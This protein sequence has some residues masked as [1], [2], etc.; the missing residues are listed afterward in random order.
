MEKVKNMGKEFSIRKIS[1]FTKDILMMVKEMDLGYSKF[2]IVQEELP[3][4]LGN[5]QMETN[6]DKVNTLTKMDLSMKDSG[7]IINVMAL[8]NWC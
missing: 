5:L 4:I 2:T 3:F 7:K 6:M 8:E 1:L